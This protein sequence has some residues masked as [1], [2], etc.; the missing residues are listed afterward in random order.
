MPPKNQKSYKVTI[1]L[2]ALFPGIGH[3]Y[4]GQRPKGLLLFFVSIILDA[5]L[6]PEGYWGIVRGEISMNMNLYLR[7][8]LLGAVRMWIVFDADKFVRRKNEK[9]LETGSEGK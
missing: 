9:V 2:S 7:L 5:T 8:V 3:M 1:G 6:L 4:A